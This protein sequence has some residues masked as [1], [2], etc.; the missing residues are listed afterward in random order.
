MGPDSDNIQ[1]HSLIY[2]EAQELSD[3]QEDVWAPGAPRPKAGTG[4]AVHD[5]GKGATSVGKDWEGI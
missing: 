1:G 4:V 5:T 3:P 2:G